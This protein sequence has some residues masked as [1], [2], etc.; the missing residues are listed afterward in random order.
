MTKPSDFKMN[1][2]YASIANVSNK[3]YSFTFGSR[4]VPT[5]NHVIDTI[6][7]KTDKAPGA[8]SQYLFSTDG[9]NFY[10]GNAFNFSFN[11]NAI[12]VE[13][14]FC[15]ISSDILRVTRISHNVTSSAQ[16][17]PTQN[18]TIKESLFIPPDLF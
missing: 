11:S 15:R 9:A 17:T 16:S 3:T 5:L 2:D 18:I 12:R 1:T 8:L 14:R 7:L 10:L 4:S 6:D 13:I